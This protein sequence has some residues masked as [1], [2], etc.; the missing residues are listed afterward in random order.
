M[1][2]GDDL[3]LGE[4]IAAVGMGILGGIA[5]AAILEALFGKTVCPNCEKSLKRGTTVCP[6]CYTQLRWE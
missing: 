3:D 1:S 2:N 6:Y 4:A 5:I